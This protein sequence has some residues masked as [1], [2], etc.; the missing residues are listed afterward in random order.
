MPASAA[1]RAANL[2]TWTPSAWSKPTQQSV[3]QQ[4]EHAESGHPH[5][6]C[7]GKASR[8]RHDTISE[9]R[10][11]TCTKPREHLRLLARILR[12]AHAARARAGRGIPVRTHA[13]RPGRAYALG[14]A[15]KLHRVAEG[16][17][18]CVQFL[19]RGSSCQRRH[20]DRVRRGD[21]VRCGQAK[22]CGFRAENGRYETKHSAQ[23]PIATQLPKTALALIN[24]D[25]GAGSSCPPRRG[26][27]TTPGPKLARVRVA[28]CCLEPTPRQPHG[29]VFRWRST[30][31]QIVVPSRG[32]QAG[33]S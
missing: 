16:A 23:K 31:H 33:R 11:V 22:K 5:A 21:H 6:G 4:H 10:S 18:R 9:S 26:T 19:G 1:C 32:A 13:R 12:K 7:S 8:I 25:A 27:G 28:M 24:V 17:T 2:H 30:P 29:A 3:E 15:I 14:L 20:C